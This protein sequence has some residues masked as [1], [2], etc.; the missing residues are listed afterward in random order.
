MCA[1]VLCECVCVSE[2][3]R[4]QIRFVCVYVFVC[5]CAWLSKEFGPFGVFLCL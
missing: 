4:S 2:Y 3:L 5:V 1:Y